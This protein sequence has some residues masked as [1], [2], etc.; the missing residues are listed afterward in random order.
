M[1]PPSPFP[2]RLQKID[3]VAEETTLDDDG[4]IVYVYV[5]QVRRAVS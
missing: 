1:E 5:M 3:M 4:D 2:W